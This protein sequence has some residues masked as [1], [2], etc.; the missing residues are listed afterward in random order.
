M[1]RVQVLLP[2]VVPL[3]LDL[4]I[5]L[6]YNLLRTLDFLSRVLFTDKALFPRNAIIN[7]D[8]KNI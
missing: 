3:R 4:G 6:R 5:W 7:F 2:R 8:N 1:L